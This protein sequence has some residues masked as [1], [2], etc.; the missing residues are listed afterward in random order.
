MLENTEIISQKHETTA[1]QQSFA[2]SA[3]TQKV[4]AKHSFTNTNL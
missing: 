3:T 1:V 4:T 2:M